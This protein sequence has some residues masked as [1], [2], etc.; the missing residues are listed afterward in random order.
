MRQGLPMIAMDAHIR[1]N[2]DVVYA[3]MN[4]DTVMFSLEQDEYYG[5]NDKGTRIWQLLEHDMSVQE[6]CTILG[7]EYD[8]SDTQCRD[9]TRRFLQ[10]L[11]DHHVIEVS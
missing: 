1:R 10:E 2:R 7:S 9:D 4:G 8:V 11:L 3:D 5:L 6:I